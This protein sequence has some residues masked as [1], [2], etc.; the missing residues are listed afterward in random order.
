M[1]NTRPEGLISTAPGG[2]GCVFLREMSS[3]K[4][5]HLPQ[6]HGPPPPGQ[7]GPMTGQDW[8]M[9]DVKA[10]RAC[11]QPRQLRRTMPGLSVV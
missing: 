1:T 8:A 2:G 4:D 10:Q 6:G 3:I 5:S 7:S 11:F 9:G